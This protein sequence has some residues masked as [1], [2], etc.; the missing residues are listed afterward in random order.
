[1]DKVFTVGFSN[2]SIICGGQDRRLVVYNVSSREYYIKQK[3]YL[4][5]SVALNNDGSLGAHSDSENHTI[6]VFHMENEQDMYILNGHE[7]PVTK[8]LFYNESQILSTGTG[9]EIFLWDLRE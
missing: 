9:K 2:E 6:L 4:V 3:D 5:Y 7:K 1:V 8:I